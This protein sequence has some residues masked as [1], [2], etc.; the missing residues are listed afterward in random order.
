MHLNIS[1]LMFELLLIV[2]SK[3]LRLAVLDTE[4]ENEPILCLLRH[5]ESSINE[6]GTVLFDDPTAWNPTRPT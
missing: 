6:K 3:L 4:S 1:T 5:H 2:G